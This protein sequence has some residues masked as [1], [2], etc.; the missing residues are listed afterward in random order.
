MHIRYMAFAALA[1]VLMIWSCVLLFAWRR[2]EPSLCPL[3]R[4]GRIRPSWP[5]MTER[6]L[7]RIVHP[8]RCEACQHRFLA[9]RA[10][11]VRDVPLGR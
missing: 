10:A 7:P 8:Y 11:W 5:K 2:G 4:S 6:I 9:R 3:C 1:I